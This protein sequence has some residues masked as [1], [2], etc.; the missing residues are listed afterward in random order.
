MA[1]QNGAENPIDQI[2]DSLESQ[3]RQQQSQLDAQRAARSGYLAKAAEIGAVYDDLALEKDEVVKLRESVVTL[4][5]KEYDRFRGNLYRS[6]HVANM[7]ALASAYD[8]L[9]SRVDANLDALNDERKKYENLAYDCDGPIGL[10]E[11]G[12]NSIVRSIQNLVN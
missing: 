7:A 6:K 4:R 11:Q 9:V 1:D 10:L 8:S 2:R 3:L 5:D 12:V